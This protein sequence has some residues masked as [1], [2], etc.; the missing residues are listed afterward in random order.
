ME[1]LDIV[2]LKIGL[3]HSFVYFSS[4]G[5]IPTDETSYWYVIIYLNLYYFVANGHCN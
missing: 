5:F 2:H 1:I 3:T 4:C